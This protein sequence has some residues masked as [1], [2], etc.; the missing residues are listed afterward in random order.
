LAYFKLKDVRNKPDCWELV[1]EER[2][3]LIP[4]QLNGEETI[5]D[6]FYNELNVL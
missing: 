2:K 3:E 6:G 1:L 4:D 5:L